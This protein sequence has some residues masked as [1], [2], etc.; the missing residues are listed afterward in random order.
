MWIELV[1]AVMVSLGAALVGFA[2][3]RN[4]ER[5]RNAMLRDIA[6]WEA[7]QSQWQKFT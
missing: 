4:Q 6:R 7:E 2:V 3:G 5:R 1:I